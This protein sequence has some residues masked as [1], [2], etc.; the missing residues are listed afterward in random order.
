MFIQ[1]DSKLAHLLPAVYVWTFL[2]ASAIVFV[3]ILALILLFCYFAEKTTV[4]RFSEEMPVEVLY[5]TAISSSGLIHPDLR[6]FNKRSP[7]TSACST[8]TGYR[9]AP[10]SRRPS[11]SEFHIPG[12]NQV[13][14]LST[15]FPSIPL[16]LDP[17]SL[18]TDSGQV[19]PE[20][21]KDS[22]LNI[23]EEDS[24]DIVSSDF[25]TKD[26]SCHSKDRLFRVSTP[27]RPL[28][29]AYQSI[30]PVQMSRIPHALSSYIR[31]DE[32]ALPPG[33]VSNYSE[34]DHKY[35]TCWSRLFFISLLPSLQSWSSETL[36]F[37]VDSLGGLR[38]RDT[39]NNEY[40]Q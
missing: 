23:G 27:L 38:M 40:T 26:D 36:S 4:V 14:P 16:E 28:N 13:A 18:T 34:V 24:F 22:F 30:E 37:N 8:D 12:Q 20:R 32:L 19:T 2:A 25:K 9:S 35:W 11:N 17:Q 7:P 10:Q 21:R 29:P 31:S 5:G 33:F 1:P 3:A 6:W 15:I 39:H